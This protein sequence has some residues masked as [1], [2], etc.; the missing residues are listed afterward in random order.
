MDTKIIDAFRWLSNDGKLILAARTLRTFAYGFLSVILAIYLKLI[1]F[2]DFY[3]GLILTATLV[4]SVIFTLVASFY[5]DKI[6]R[7]KI[8]IVYAA[9]MSLSGAI[10]FVTT[11]YLALIISALIGTINVTGTETGA[12]LSIEQAA[13]PQTLSN[14]K[15]RNTVYAI[16]NMVGTFAMSAGVLVSGLP[17]FFVHEYGLSQIESIK[18]LF[19]LYSI[20]GLA[21][22]GIY[23]LLSTKVE[24]QINNNNDKNNDHSRPLKQVLTPKSKQIISKLSSLFALD[25]FAGGFVIQSI[26]SLWFFTKFG[27]DL[28]TL[29]Y[30][31]S[32]AGV[33]T[34]FS[35]LAAAKIADRI[36]LI[37]TMVFTHIPSNILLILV[38]FAPTFPL[39][40]ALYLAR[41]TLSQMDVPTRQSYIVAVVREDERTAAAGITNVS[42]NITQAI[43][44]SLAGYILQSLSLLSAPFVLGGVLKIV[45][46]VA[47]YFN[48]KGIKPPDERNER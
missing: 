37:N 24:I 32:I 10:F 44:P 14:I 8:L 19:L 30:I 46:D 33:L 31:F 3:I 18:P 40:V 45:Y 25:S 27:V 47:L 21:V 13:L 7:R 38:A 11:N 36:G 23:C 34:A 42:R 4:N 26:V 29:S 43:S 15:K 2:E 5:A 17:E 28:T 41:M 39:A 9:L 1:G 6:G 22:L 12:F 35:Y 20:I 48:F 16:Y